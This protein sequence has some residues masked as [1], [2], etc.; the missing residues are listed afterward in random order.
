MKLRVHHL[1][2]CAL[3][4][5]KGYSEAFVKNMRDISCRL[6]PKENAV[7]DGVNPYAGQ[8]QDED[9]EI[10]LCILPDLICSKCPN[11]IE[12]ACSLDDNQ[13]VSKDRHLADAFGLVCGRSYRKDKLKKAVNEALTEEI[14]EDSCH[15][16]QWYLEG[17]CSYQLLRERYRS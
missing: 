6:F 5:G 17:L 12:G 2:C 10:E 4:E 15:R 9:E 8:A 3:F 1:F 11:L 13:V 16:C 7:V 14:F